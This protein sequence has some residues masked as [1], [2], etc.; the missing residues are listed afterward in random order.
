MPAVI[1]WI[2]YGR[3]LVLLQKVTPWQIPPITPFHQMELMELR[4]QKRGIFDFTEDDLDF[5]RSITATYLDLKEM[6]Q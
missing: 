1:E 5:I 6:W 3:L 2:T 4:D